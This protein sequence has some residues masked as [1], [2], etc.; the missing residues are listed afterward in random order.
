MRVDQ[1]ATAPSSVTA[2]TP[3]RPVK[4]ESRTQAAPARAETTA[5]TP[6]AG[7]RVS[8]SDAARQAA[9]VAD[10]ASSASVDAATEAAAEDFAPVISIIEGIPWA[11]G[12]GP[13]AWQ[14]SQGAA[15]ASKLVAPEVS[16]QD[17]IETRSP[18]NADVPAQASPADEATSTESASESAPAQR[19]AP[20]LAREDA[21]RLADRRKAS[22]V[23]GHE[24]QPASN[25]SL[26]V[27]V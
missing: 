14:A 26:N 10:A 9:T 11:V 12:V 17:S 25:P 21:A 13:S 27:K 3:S 24:A 4:E 16:A 1:T 20:Q 5:S 22:L 19:Q 6:M 18:S 2:L 7:L 23:Y 8:I 15:A